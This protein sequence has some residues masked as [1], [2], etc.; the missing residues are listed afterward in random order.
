MDN[1]QQQ[2][3]LFEGTQKQAHNLSNELR[4]YAKLMLIILTVNK[5]RNVVQDSEEKQSS[6][7]S[8][9]IL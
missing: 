3:T 4:N 2:S 1:F 6:T 5:C 8:E 9:W 7:E